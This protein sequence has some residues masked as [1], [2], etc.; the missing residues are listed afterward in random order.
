MGYQDNP[1]ILSKLENLALQLT[2]RKAE[3]EAVG[4]ENDC[5]AASVNPGILEYDDPVK[6]WTDLARIPGTPS[7]PNFTVDVCPSERPPTPAHRKSNQCGRSRSWPQ[8]RA[9]GTSSPAIGWHLFM[10]LLSD[11]LYD[12][13]WQIDAYAEMIAT[14]KSNESSTDSW[15]LVL[16]GTPS[17]TY[18]D[19]KRWLRGR[20][21]WKD[22]LH[23]WGWQL[24]PDYEHFESA[25]PETRFDPDFG[26]K[27]CYVYKQNIRRHEKRRNAEKLF[28]QAQ[29]EFEYDLTPK[30]DLHTDASTPALRRTWAAMPPK[31]HPVFRTRLVK[32]RHSVA[33][34]EA[35]L[36]HGT[37]RIRRN[38]FSDISSRL[39]G[40]Q[41]D[42]VHLRHSRQPVPGIKHV[43][44]WGDDM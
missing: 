8:S 4:S 38:S 5:T 42:H 21:K 40:M 28:E 12:Q 13:Q 33:Q 20:N 23:C 37:Q 11:A 19:R 3:S 22:D 43:V 1:A 34:L 27:V 14:E 29:N 35:G 16:S 9:S 39:L 36:R 30:L 41:E 7:S 24:T 15:G 31:V 44:W 18:F 26:K 32:R 25:A 10:H 2:Q 6:F 17:P